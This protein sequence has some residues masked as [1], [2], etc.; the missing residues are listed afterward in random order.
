MDFPKV[1]ASTQ[2]RRPS[3]R[4]ARTHNDS[5]FFST[6]LLG[7]RPSWRHFWSE[8]RRSTTSST[9]TTPTTWPS[10]SDPSPPPLCRGRP[11][12]AHVNTRAFS[13]RTH[14]RP[15]GQEGPHKHA[16]KQSSSL[17]EA[18]REGGG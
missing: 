3:S 2:V 18:G 8:T 17:Q 15:A 14:P 13:Q 5:D 7:R 10:G 12:H 16:N 6:L 1:I 4:H 9:T 11:A